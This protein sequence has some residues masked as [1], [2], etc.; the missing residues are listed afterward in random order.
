MQ[1]TVLVYVH[2]YLTFYLVVF[3]TVMFCQ[4]LVVTGNPELQA[5]I[6]IAPDN[7]PIH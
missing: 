3:L 2:K 4:E 5:G 1:S 6:V 7:V